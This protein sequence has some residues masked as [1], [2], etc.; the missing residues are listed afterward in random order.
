[1]FTL[2]LAAAIESLSGT[3]PGLGLDQTACVG[4]VGG[5]INGKLNPAVPLLLYLPRSAATNAALIGRY[6]AGFGEPI[7]HNVGNAIIADPDPANGV[8]NHG[9][10]DGEH[11]F[12]TLDPYLRGLLGLPPNYQWTPA[13]MADLN[14]CYNARKWIQGQLALEGGQPAKPVAAPVQAPIT[15]SPTPPI[16]VSPPLA[17]LPAPIAPPPI[18][19]PATNPLAALAGLFPAG[20]DI[21]KIL[22][23]Y[24]VLQQLGLVK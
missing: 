11:V 4:Y 23:L 1:M 14:A 9:W 8:N 17:P 12:T 20:T 13:D 24:S 21:A 19:S 3:H 2:S 5:Q 22:A 6:G 7:A 10:V 18:P 16:V 15:V